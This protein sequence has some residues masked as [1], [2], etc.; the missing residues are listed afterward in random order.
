VIR[1]TID[2][3]VLASGFAGLEVRQST[4]GAIVRH[5]RAGHF[6]LV[7]SDHLLVE[8]RRTFAKPYFTSRRS[9]T[10][11]AAALTL[12]SREATVIVP[13]V[14]V[15]GVATHPEDDLVLATAA[16]ALVDYL[17]T[18]T[19]RCNALAPIGTSALSRRANFLRCLSEKEP[20]VESEHPRTIES[21]LG[22]HC[23]LLS[24][25]SG[26]SIADQRDQTCWRAR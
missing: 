1:A 17:I 6:T 7:I 14:D 26:W 8:L 18:G 24:R 22:L 15:A 19:S 13:G 4:P 9:P 12:L 16:T 2:T 11:I 10:Q 23:Y 20:S 25:R 21:G 3:N 5:W